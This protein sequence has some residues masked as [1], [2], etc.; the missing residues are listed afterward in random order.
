[1][2]YFWGLQGGVREVHFASGHVE[3]VVACIALRSVLRVAVAYRIEPLVRKSPNLSSLGLYI[4]VEE[5]TIT[6]DEAI[7]DVWL[8]I[9]SVWGL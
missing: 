5:C 1:M 3:H 8:R 4:W 9:S 7:I 2:R 6:E